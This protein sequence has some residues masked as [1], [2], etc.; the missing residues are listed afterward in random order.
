MDVTLKQYSAFICVLMATIFIPPIV[1]AEDLFADIKAGM[2]KIVTI[3]SGDVR[4]YVQGQT[5]SF[6]GIPYAEPPVDE[7][8]W[9]P[10]QPPLAWD[11]IRDAGT[12]GGFSLQTSL[13][14][15]FGKR[16]INEDCLYLN[17][18]AP[19]DASQEEPL[20]VMIWIHGGGLIN[21]R[22][23]DYDP[24]KL[25]RNGNVIVV[26]INYR[27]N[28]FGFFSHPALSS[29]GA[30]T[31]YGI[32]DQQAAMRWVQRNI[33]AF[34]G[35]P[36]NV[37]LFGESAGGLSITMNMVSPSAEGLFHKVILMSAVPVTALPSR[38][39]GEQSGID[40][41]NLLGCTGTDAAVLAAMRSKT[42]GEILEKAESYTADTMRAYDG[43]IIPGPLQDLFEQGKFH[44]VPIMIG[45]TF[46]ESTWFVSFPELSTGNPVT[47]LNYHERLA[48]T[49]G[50]EQSALCVEQKYPATDFPS[51]SDALATAQTSWQFICPS[52]RAMASFATHAPVYVYEFMDTTAPQYFE[53]VS[54]TY[55]A[56]HTLELQYLFP[57]F[58]GSMGS[59]Q[60]LSADQ[61]YLSDVMVLYW[62]NFARSGNPNGA[63]LPEW[64][65]WTSDAPQ[66]QLLDLVVTTA[67]DSGIDRKCEF[68]D[69]LGSCQ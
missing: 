61:E 51:P 17:V 16:N 7:L 13:L 12:F 65:R 39:A 34:G 59:P 64:P 58:H 22:S 67:K 11:G 36:N 5:A 3:D 23:D 53:P 10:P 32:L 45:N 40:F 27:L 43:E 35:D 20:P 31:N 42:I 33:S 68:W 9:K 38:E 44:K 41:A 21:G 69:S 48:S 28:L 62:T 8:R 26:T 29:E 15:V 1:F 56:A 18:F 47:T 60:P 46:N 24:R 63:D 25:V 49:F 2:P 55:G 50:G 4:G 37:T 30:S 19:S 57:R 66:T 54:F 14:G 52:R 6:L